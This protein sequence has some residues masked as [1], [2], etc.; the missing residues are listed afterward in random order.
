[1]SVVIVI[2]VPSD[3]YDQ[4]TMHT[5]L[6]SLYDSGHTSPPLASDYEGSTAK[7]ERKKER[8]PTT[9]K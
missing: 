6:Q 8:N 1:M 4:S 9:L 5:V 2:K 3:A 7:K